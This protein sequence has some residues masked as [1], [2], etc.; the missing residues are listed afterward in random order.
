MEIKMPGREIPPDGEAVSKAIQEL[1]AHIK[2]GLKE[3]YVPNAEEVRSMEKAWMG[4]APYESTNI[5]PEHYSELE[6]L[7]RALKEY[8]SKLDNHLGVYNVDA[9]QTVTD[10][11]KEILFKLKEG[12]NSIQRALLTAKL[13]EKR[14]KP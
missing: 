9:L 1:D 3:A 13:N 10:L 12:K 6:I 8:V 14:R 2:A 5:R 4:D 7:F 11:D